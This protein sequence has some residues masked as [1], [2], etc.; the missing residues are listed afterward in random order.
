MKSFAQL[1]V[2]RLRQH[3][4]QARPLNRVKRLV[5]PLVKPL[6]RLLAKSLAK[7]RAKPLA[8]KAAPAQ[9]ILLP[10]EAAQDSHQSSAAAAQHKQQSPRLKPKPF[11][12]L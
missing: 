8:Q 4:A 12:S 9:A 2:Y 6:G 10:L 5:R 3:K 1:Q 7:L 11:K